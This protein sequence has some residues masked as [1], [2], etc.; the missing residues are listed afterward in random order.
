MRSAAQNSGASSEAGEWLPAV[1]L[2]NSEL[3]LRILHG[4]VAVG[5]GRDAPSRSLGQLRPPY[6]WGPAPQAHA[7]GRLFPGGATVPHVGT[8][9]ANSARR[10][11]CSVRPALPSL[12]PRMTPSGQASR[13]ARRQGWRR[14]LPLSPACKEEWSVGSKTLRARKPPCG[15][16]HLLTPSQ[17]SPNTEARLFS[18]CPGLYYR[19]TLQKSPDFSV[20]HYT[21]VKPDNVVCTL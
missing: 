9:M 11:Q 1:A 16:A 4:D 12:P 2:Q 5:K 17:R 8:Q 10:W 19:V 7:Q 3:H 15:V 18:M 14:S 6:P 20:P 21:S 13:S